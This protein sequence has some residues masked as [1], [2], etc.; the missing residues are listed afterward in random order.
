MFRSL[1]ILFAPQKGWK[2][3]A[4]QSWNVLVVFLFSIL[5]LLVAG[6]VVEGWGMAQFGAQTGS[7]GRVI[8]L[9]QNQII[10]YEVIQFVLGLILLFFGG[11]FIQWV[12]VGFHTETSYRQAFTL[13]AY[14]LTPI[15]WMR[16]LDCVPSVPSW[17][18]WG[19][20]ALGIM[21]LLYNGVALVIQPN[22]SVGF[23]MYL[24][25]S[26]ILVALTALC[27]FLA[28]GVAYGKFNIKPIIGLLFFPI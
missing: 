12:C 13:T 23:G 27:H 19:I 16:F 1:I 15:F 28:Q 25:S 5:P 17:L 9:E 20:G 18:C 7:I 11:K 14:S 26:L 24:V 3:I 2:T 21:M 8:H 6:C 4:D 10:T 22:T